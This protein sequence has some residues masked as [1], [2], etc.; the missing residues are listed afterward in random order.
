MLITG[1]TG[2]RTVLLKLGLPG[3]AIAP[4]SHPPRSSKKQN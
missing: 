3:A 1:Q 2:F 4:S